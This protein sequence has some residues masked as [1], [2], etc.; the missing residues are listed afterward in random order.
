MQG[1][2]GRSEAESVGNG[3]RGEGRYI[4]LVAI[5]CERRVRGQAVGEDRKSV[6]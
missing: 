1:S 4:G 6:V 2:Q 5:S 3:V